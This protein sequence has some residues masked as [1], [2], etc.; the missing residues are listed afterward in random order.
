MMRVPFV[1][2]VFCVLF[3]MAFG[4]SYIAGGLAQRFTGACVM[5]AL[6]GHC[7]FSGLGGQQLEGRVKGLLWL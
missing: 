3:L 2:A 7:G 5:F 1:P 6:L 4:T